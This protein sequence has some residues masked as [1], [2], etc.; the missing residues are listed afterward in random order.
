MKIILLL[1][2]IFL[3]SCEIPK[4]GTLKLSNDSG[5]DV[6][7]NVELSNEPVMLTKINEFNPKT[8]PFPM[9]KKGQQVILD[10]EDAY[11]EYSIA[12]VDVYAIREYEKGDSLAVNLLTLSVQ[13]IYG[14][15][16]VTIPELGDE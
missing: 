5:E 4:Q 7:Y 16:F 9:L 11:E 13:D 1:T 2:I 15:W 6:Y 3:C 10:F 12:L 8:P 14:I